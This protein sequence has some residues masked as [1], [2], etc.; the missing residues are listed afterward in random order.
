MN[1][2]R[3]ISIM[4][5]K[6]SV[7]HNDRKFTAQNVDK[8][9]TKNNVVYCNENI[10]TVYHKL[11]DDAVKRYNAKQTRSDRIIKNYYKK[12]SQESKQEKPFTE[13][14]IQIGDKDNM[15][16]ETE[17]GQ[18][19]KKILD[20]YMKG[21][22]ERNPNLYVFS[23]H[24]HMDEATPH[25]HIDFVPFTTDSKRGLDTRVSMKGALKQQGFSGTGRSDTELNQWRD[26]EKEVL[27]K[28][29]L[30]HGIEWE[31]KGTH[32]KHKSVSEFKRDKLIEEVENLQEQ[33]KDL[34]QTMSAYKQAEEYAHLTV[35]KIKNNDDFDIPEPPSLMTAKTYKTKFIEPF[36]KRIMKIIENLARRCYRAE[37]LAEQAEAKIRPFEQKNIE[38]ENRLWYKNMALSKAEVKVRDF[39]RIRNHFGKET[40]NQWLK[41]IT[42]LGKNRSKSSKEI[43][44]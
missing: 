28:I 4:T 5:G 35:Q 24:L 17:N 37:K 16:A 20:D 30:T 11:F 13:I 26:S 25:L 42:R 44:R 40:I 43:E 41:E 12:I 18:L 33:K 3:T 22:Q 23:A 27:S 6:G 14:I 34:L 1:M 29:M 8:E 2:Q 36:I 38:L 10:R 19:A 32:E 9:R 31:Q 15:G 39:D 21:F 7:N